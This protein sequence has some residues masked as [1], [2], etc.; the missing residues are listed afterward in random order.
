MAYSTISDEGYNH[1][2]VNHSYEFQ[3]ELTNAHTDNIEATWKWTKKFTIDEGGCLDPHLQLMLDCYS[4][5]AMWIDNNE[6]NAFRTICKAISECHHHF[7]V[8]DFS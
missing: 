8:S 5:K 1:I 2:E 3:D 7:R 6:E 4:F